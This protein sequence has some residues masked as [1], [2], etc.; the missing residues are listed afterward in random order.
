MVIP[1]IVVVVAL[2]L[3]IIGL[4]VGLVLY[5]KQHL[6]QPANRRPESTGGGGAAGN[7]PG[8]EEH[9]LEVV[10][11]DHVAVQFARKEAHFQHH[12]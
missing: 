9:L 6:K 4:F 3:I 5:R 1:I 10:G 11:T 8:G 12:V 2:S 7:G